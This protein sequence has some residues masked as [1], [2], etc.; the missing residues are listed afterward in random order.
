MMAHGSMRRIRAACGRLGPRGG[1][2][3]VGQDANA[4]AYAGAGALA[5]PAARQTL[6]AC[7]SEQGVTGARPWVA[8][9]AARAASVG[10][11]RG[12][13]LGI[14]TVRAVRRA[15][16]P[17]GASLFGGSCDSYSRGPAQTSEGRS[18]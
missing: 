12:E 3:K 9:I 17:S 11:S 16:S 2:D 8:M 18:E 7:A 5:T 6:S 14:L 1:A 13:M 15:L 10:R 4:C